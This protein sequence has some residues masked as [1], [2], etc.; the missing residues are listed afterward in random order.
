MY[1][2][3]PLMLTVGLLYCTGGQPTGPNSVPPSMESGSATPNWVYGSWTMDK[4]KTVRRMMQVNGQNFDSYTPDER[5]TIMTQFNLD[6]EVN[7]GP[8]RWNAVFRE[9]SRTNEGNGTLTYEERGSILVISMKEVLEDGKVKIDRLEIHKMG[10]NLL[11]MRFMEEAED[12]S[13]ILQRK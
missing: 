12:V 5:Q 10:P 9:G 13:F 4:E 8:E 1:R 11:R 6:L 7:L 2:I 3:L